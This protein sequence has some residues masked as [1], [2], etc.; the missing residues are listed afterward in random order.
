VTVDLAPTRFLQDTST[1]AWQAPE[2]AV[3]TA[4]VGDPLAR[5]SRTR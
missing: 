2:T 3:D 5:V 4:D 1:I